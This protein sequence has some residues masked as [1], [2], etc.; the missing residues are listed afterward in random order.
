[1]AENESLDLGSSPRMRVVFDAF[2]NGASC[3]EATSK[4]ENALIGGLRVQIGSDV[5]DGSIQ[6]RLEAIKQQ[7]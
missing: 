3:P 6:A 4:L 7:R 2:R 1:M 5:W